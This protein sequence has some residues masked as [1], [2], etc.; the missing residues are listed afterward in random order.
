MS[1]RLS[2]VDFGPV[3]LPIHSSQDGF[4]VA[5]TASASRSEDA[6]K[7]QHLI[8]NAS[9]RSISEEGSEFTGSNNQTI[10]PG[11]RISPGN[12]KVNALACLRLASSIAASTE[13]IAARVE[14]TLNP[15]FLPQSRLSIE[16]TSDGLCF[17]LQVQDANLRD[18]ISQDL[19]TIVNSIGVHLQ[20]SVQ[21]RLFSESNPLPVK[22][23][24]WRPGGIA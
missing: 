23:A 9:G 2:L 10:Y 3:A 19:D 4:E 7:F 6:M 1:K 24:S 20:A 14:L 13:K 5:L 8:D 17:D 21:L 11:S 16:R 18:E 15:D 12:A 22:Q